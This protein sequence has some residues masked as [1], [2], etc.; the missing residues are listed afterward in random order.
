MN[1]ISIAE[2]T[3]SEIVRQKVNLY[4]TSSL[5]LFKDYMNNRRSEWEED[6]ELELEQ[7]N[8]MA[9]KKYNKLPIS[10]R[11]SKKDPKDAHIPD[12]LGV[13]QNLAY[14]SKKSSDKSNTSNMESTKGKTEYIR[15]IPPWM[16]EE[17]KSGVVNKT[18]DE[19]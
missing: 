2:E 7:V 12:L 18:K 4:S 5:T 14:D 6:K 11:W 8:A 10:W 19:K 16:P 17:P 3:Y 9:L 15:D 13:T 1:E